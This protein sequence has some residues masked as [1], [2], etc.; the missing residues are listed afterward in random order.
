MA[1][2]GLAWPALVWL[3]QCHVMASKPPHGR[4]R[5]R[6]RYP[7]V[8]FVSL[9]LLSTPPSSLFLRRDSVRG[10]PAVPA[11]RASLASSARPQFELLDPRHGEIRGRTRCRTSSAQPRARSGTR[12][13]KPNERGEPS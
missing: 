2:P 5:G 8:A 3:A 13:Q 10:P 7:F 6:S 12:G 1:W 4:M 11:A 9:R